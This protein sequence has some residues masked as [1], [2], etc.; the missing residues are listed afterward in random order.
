MDTQDVQDV[1]DRMHGT[2]TRTL[3]LMEFSSHW[4]TA[5]TVEQWEIQSLYCLNNRF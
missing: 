3:G 5:P 1:Q 2:R 4:S